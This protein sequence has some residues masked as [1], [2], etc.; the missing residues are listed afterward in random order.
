MQ[1]ASNG[2]LI[3]SSTTTGGGT[4]TTFNVIENGG[5]VIDSS[6]GAT[7][8]YIEFSTGGTPKMFIAAAGNVGIGT[9]DTQGYKL[10]INTNTL[11]INFKASYSTGNPLTIARTTFIGTEVCETQIRAYNPANGV[12]ADLGFLVMNTSSVL[13]EMIR[14][15]G[16]TERVGILTDAPSHTLDVSGRI[17]AFTA[18][19]GVSPRTDLGGTIIA[20]GSTRAGLYILTSG[21]AAGSYGSIWWGNGNT[22]TDAF[23]SVENDTRAMRFGTADGTRMSILSSGNVLVNNTTSYYGY[24]SQ[25]RGA[26]YSYSTADDRGIVIFPNQGTPNIQGVIPSSGNANNI[27]LQGS[28]GNVGIGTTSPLQPS[29]GRKVVTIN[30]DSGGSAILNFGINGALKTYLYSD[31]TSTFLEGVG[32]S[33]T[34]NASASNFIALQ[35]ADIDRMRITSGGNV[36]I[37]T[38][39]PSAADGSS[40]TFQLKNTVVLQNVIGTQALFANNAYYDGAWKRVNAAGF[41]A[42][43]RINADNGQNGIAFHVA[44]SGAANSVI[45]NWDSTDIKMRINNSGNIGIGTTTDAGYKLDVNGTARISN[46][47]IIQNG[48][49]SLVDNNLPQ[50]YFRADLIPTNGRTIGTLNYG[51]RF[52]ST[53]YGTGASIDAKAVGTWSSTNYGTNLIFSTVTENTDINTERMRITAAGNV[54]IGTQTDNGSRLRVNGSVALPHVTKS[55][56]YTLDNTDYTVGFDCASNRTATLPDA[57]TCAGRIYVIYHYNTGGGT[58]SV[59]LDG[60]GSQTINGATT[61]SLAPYCDFTSI[62]IQSNGSNWIIISSNLTA[63]CL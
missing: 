4:K 59:T 41:V 31:S 7:A 23:I 1:I 48:S 32:T 33:I 44:A 18:S 20:E 38:T 28:G 55:A 43:M 17:R 21:T 46:T 30:G 54:L 60:N 36:G 53:T 47:T 50:Q 29:A 39:S 24:Q 49:F 8:R 6:E 45:S 40:V 5:V 2:N 35:T 57:T 42:A 12:D 10:G 56:N 15:K 16:S 61:Y 58:R 13:K 22:N 3:L 52:N 14:I 11:G 62:V 34:L 25:V 9:T 37:G 27:A 19:S 26:F 51:A 63:D